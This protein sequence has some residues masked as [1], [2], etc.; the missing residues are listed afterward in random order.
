M[1]H[2]KNAWFINFTGIGNGVIIA[3]ILSC[4]EKSNPTTKYFHTE[5]QVLSNKWF[6]DK[7]RLNNLIGFS[8]LAWRRFNEQDH[9]RI[10]SFIQENKIDLI[11]NVRNEGQKYDLGYYKFKDLHSANN[12]LLFWDLNFS[13]IENRISPTNL[14]ADIIE[15]IKE[16]GIDF[17]SYKPDW[18]NSVR[19]P[20]AKNK[21]GFGMAASQSNKRWSIKKWIQ[22]GQMILEKKDRKIFLFAGNSPQEISEASEV[23]SSLGSDRCI[24]VSQKTIE[25]VTEIIGGL[26]CFFSNDTGLLHISVAVDT[27]TIGIYTSTNPNVWSPNDKRNFISFENSFMKLCPDR[28]IHC[29]NC[30]HYYDVCPAIE[31]YGDDIIPEKVF[32]ASTEFST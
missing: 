3:P 13:V 8:P 17:S 15:L 22:L 31:K 24:L 5:N 32:E 27:P 23:F 1:Q 6:T 25:S 20:N 30:F 21:F 28:K 10:N 16:N 4:F 26:E 12:E 11:V 18:L 7:A 2:K 14:T 19:N 9:E 29:G